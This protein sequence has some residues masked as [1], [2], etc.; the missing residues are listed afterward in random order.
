MQTNPFLISMEDKEEY[1]NEDYAYAQEK[2]NEK[3]VEI[4]NLIDS[5]Y[6]RDIQFNT[7]LKL[8]K[9]RCTK[10][11]KQKL[12]DGLSIPSKKIIKI[13]DG[14]DGKNCIVCCTPL[15][16][17]RCNSSQT[18]EKSLEEIGFNGYFYLFNGGFPNPRGIE[19]KY[20]GVPYCFKI[21]MMLEAKKMGFEK[22]IWI[23][24]ACYATK[25]PQILFDILTSQDA[26]FRAF[27]PGLF[28][29][30]DNVVFPQTIELLN[31]IT[32][33]DIR[34]DINVCT[35]VFGLN[36]MSPMINKFI[37]E[38]YEMVEIGLP[39]LSYFPE[40]VVMAAIL[41]K[42]EYKYVFYNH[43]V[44]THLFIH[45]IYTNIDMAKQLGYF[46]VQRSYC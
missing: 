40:E 25:N 32:N 26:I 28:E 16:D 10:S 45:Q 43:P 30:Y 7:P 36:M 31:Q 12:I 18:I 14:G 41:N 21:F 42:P 35:I 37:D 39:F 22:V 3:V 38:Y 8:I 33:K 6:P 29:N 2:L 44:S 20:A 15:S 27:P 11:V 46:F 4:E 34:Y 19:L 9:S 1:N 5:L 17:D 13:G 24:S 23:D